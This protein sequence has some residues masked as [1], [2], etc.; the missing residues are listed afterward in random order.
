MIYSTTFSQ[1]FFIWGITTDRKLTPQFSIP[2]SIRFK[3]FEKNEFQ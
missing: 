3:F 1:Y 2:M